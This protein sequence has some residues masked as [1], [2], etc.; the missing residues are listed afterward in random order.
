M[1]IDPKDPKVSIFKQCKYL[2]LHRSTYYFHPQ[3]E[4]AENLSSDGEDRQVP[5]G[6]SGPWEPDDS[7]RI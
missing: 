6:E 4:S 1:L 2:N 5:Y 3:G 7:G